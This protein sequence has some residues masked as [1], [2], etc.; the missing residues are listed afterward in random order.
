MNEMFIFL[1]KM[2]CVLVDYCRGDF[3]N[4]AQPYRW[5]TI[6]DRWSLIVA[7]YHTR[8]FAFLDDVLASYLWFTSSNLPFS[9]NSSFLQISECLSPTCHLTRRDPCCALLC[10][11]STHL[12]K[13]CSSGLCLYRRYRLT[14]PDEVRAAHL[15][16]VLLG[17]VLNEECVAADW[18]SDIHF[19]AQILIVTFLKTQPNENTHK[20]TRTHTHT[21]TQT[22]I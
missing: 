12:D 10:L 19:V 6:N 3:V 9:T 8:F 4:R 7:E 22:H 18:S 11:S 13:L 20:H 5:S 2:C 17:K 1:P 14:L 15:P 21:H 16:L